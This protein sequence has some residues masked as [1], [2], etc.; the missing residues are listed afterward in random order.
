MRCS[1]KKWNCAGCAAVVLG[2]II[3][4]SLILPAGFWWFAVGAALIVAGLL[5]CARG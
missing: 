5:I 4:L 3:L 2:G 1:R